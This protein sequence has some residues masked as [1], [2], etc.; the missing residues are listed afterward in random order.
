MTFT[1]KLLFGRTAILRVEDGAQIPADP[2]NRDYQEFLQSG[3]VALPADPPPIPT[4]LQKI[5]LYDR[6]TLFLLVELVNVLLAKG[7]IL[8]TDFA[9]TTRTVFTRAKALLATAEQLL[10]PP[11]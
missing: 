5:D 8:P 6:Y 3:A 2:F 1:Y 9:A 11:P 7:T 10:P 4:D